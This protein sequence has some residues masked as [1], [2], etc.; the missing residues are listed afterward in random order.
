MKKVINFIFLLLAGA[1]EA[2]AIAPGTMVQ[3]TLFSADVVSSACHVVVEA[4]GGG[5]SRLIFDNYRK[6]I[7]AAV[8]P[9]D[10]IVRL[11]EPG[12][13]V[14]GCSAF[15]AGQI[16]TMDFGNP[17]QLDAGGVVTRGA[18]DGIRVEVRALDAQ[19]DFRGRLT[20]ENHSVNYPV[21]FAA[22]GQLRFRAQSVIPHGVKAGEYSG[23]LSFVVIYQ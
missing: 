18:G 5:G 22:K 15:L 14:Q 10:F 4:V 6:S 21:D 2:C 1:G 13:T 3:R 17:G 19:A 7:A 16:A 23:A 20:Q 8:P 11:F 12:A 9:R